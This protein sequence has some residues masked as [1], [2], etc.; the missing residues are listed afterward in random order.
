MESSKPISSFKP[1]TFVQDYNYKYFL[2]EKINREWILDSPEIQSLCNEANRN[3]G[4][5]NA[6]S[7]L[8]PDV[9]FFIRM[10]I[11]KEATTSSRIEG[12]RTKMEEAFL[13]EE[14]VSPE[15]RDDWQEVQNYIDAMN[16]AIG[17]LEKLPV[18]PRLIRKTHKILMHGV[19][20]KYRQPG[21]Y[22]K[23]QNW[24]GGANV[25]Q[26]QESWLRNFI[27]TR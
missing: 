23:S 22:R 15:K 17:E 16:F 6:F 11:T 4:E 2:P 8:I 13:K 18:S 27:K 24:I 5:L 14:D 26:K 7:Q 1:G 20:G 3:L 19:R 9:D 10:H 21:A 25:P 12:T